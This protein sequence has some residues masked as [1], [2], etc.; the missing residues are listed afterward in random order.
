MSKLEELV[1]EEKNGA[2]DNLRANIDYGGLIA[3][4]IE[5]PWAGDTET[6]FG[7]SGAI[8]LTRE[9]ALLLAG[10]LQKAADVVKE[11]K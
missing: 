4:E 5:E 3:L 10:W 8:R 7:R 1:I 11:P 2:G 6:G 9:K